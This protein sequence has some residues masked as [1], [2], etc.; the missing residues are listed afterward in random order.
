[1]KK[2]SSEN[3][4]T[5]REEFEARELQF[6]QLTEALRAGDHN[7]VEKLG[8]R[9]LAMLGR[10]VLRLEEELATMPPNRRSEQAYCCEAP[11]VQYFAP[12]SRAT[13]PSLLV[14][15]DDKRARALLAPNPDFF[16]SDLPAT[17]M[18]SITVTQ[19]ITRTDKDWEIYME[20]VRQGVDWQALVLLLMQNTQNRR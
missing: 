13:R 8:R 15:P 10:V 7:A 6:V 17:A 1:M 5:L 19:Q 3:A 4:E 16:R 11:P 14:E 20:E 9:D 2:I 12:P 18:Q